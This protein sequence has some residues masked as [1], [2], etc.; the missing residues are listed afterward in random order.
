M[1]YPKPYIGKVTEKAVEA[2]N[3]AMTLREKVICPHP[4]HELAA[5]AEKGYGPREDHTY[6]VVV[7]LNGKRL[8]GE[9][10]LWCDPAW[11]SGKNLWQPSLKLNEQESGHEDC[12][13]CSGNEGVSEATTKGLTAV[14]CWEAFSPLLGVYKLAKSDKPGHWFLFDMGCKD[15][16]ELEDDQRGLPRFYSAWRHQVE[17]PVHGQFVRRH[18]EFNA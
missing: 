8:T 9:L 10:H 15:L 18:C 6:D 2:T 16:G 14:A 12:P 4:I 1:A 5:R 11:D 7:V 17:C 13:L 3:A